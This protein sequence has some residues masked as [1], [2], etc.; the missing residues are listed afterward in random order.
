MG[1]SDEPGLAPS[2]P[3]GICEKCV[4]EAQARPLRT[5]L[6][7]W[8]LLLG[9]GGTPLKGVGVGPAYAT[10][11]LT[12]GVMHHSESSAKVGGGHAMRKFLENLTIINTN[13]NTH[14]VW[15]N[16]LEL[17]NTKMCVREE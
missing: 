14:L 2:S 7:P 15:V 1:G 16:I 4:R 13:Y 12:F 9:A 11:S 10:S 6:P 3:P 17:I 5:P 8:R